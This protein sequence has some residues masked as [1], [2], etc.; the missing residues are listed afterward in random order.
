M[1]GRLDYLDSSIITRAD[2]NV[3]RQGHLRQTDSTRVRVVGRTDDLEGGDDRVAHVFRNLAESQV[4]VDQGSGM[5]WEPARL[6]GESTTADG[7]FGS[8]GRPGHSTTWERSD[9]DARTRLKISCL[10]G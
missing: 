3:G 9:C 6:E 7:P 8:V 5:T 4:D 2:T 1:F 10:Q